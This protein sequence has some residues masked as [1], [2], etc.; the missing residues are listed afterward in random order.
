MPLFASVYKFT[1]KKLINQNKYYKKESETGN[2]G[3]HQAPCLVLILNL[4]GY[5]TQ[6]HLVLSNNFPIFKVY[7]IQRVTTAAYTSVELWDDVVETCSQEHTLNWLLMNSTSGLAPDPFLCC[8]S[9]AVLSAPNGGILNTT[10]N[11]I[12]MHSQINVSADI[13][14]IRQAYG[15]RFPLIDLCNCVHAAPARSTAGLK[16]S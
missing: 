11:Q 14:I 12:P 7:L 10:I 4:L 9:L 16:M 5:F 3:I 1:S 13:F 2:N 6:P 15:P 8:Q